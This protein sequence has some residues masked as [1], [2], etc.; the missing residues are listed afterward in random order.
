MEFELLAQRVAAITGLNTIQATRLTTMHLYV[1]GGQN[2]VIAA[3]D[4]HIARSL[5]EQII[6]VCRL[7]AID[8]LDALVR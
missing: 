7:S 5:A 2:L 3:C 1:L 6:E 4:P 8:N